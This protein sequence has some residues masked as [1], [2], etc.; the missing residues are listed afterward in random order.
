MCLRLELSQVTAKVSLFVWDLPFGPRRLTSLE[1]TL[2]SQPQNTHTHG[3]LPHMR[4]T[5]MEESQ[6]SVSCGYGIDCICLFFVSFRPH[7]AAR[8]STYATIDRRAPGRACERR[9]SNGFRGL[10]C[11]ILKTRYSTVKRKA[12]RRL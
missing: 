9:C 7:S 4:D 8:A 2:F 10:L 12:F 3:L 6:H 5:A 1:Q 11:A